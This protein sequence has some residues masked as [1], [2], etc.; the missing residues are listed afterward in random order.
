MAFHAPAQPAHILVVEDD[1]LLQ[2]ALSRVL[3]AAG[4]A[5]S[6]YPQAE[7]MLAEL[8]RRA[9]AGGTQAPI[10]ILMDVN[11]GSLSGID[12]QKLVR[13]I[14]ASTPVVFM[15][16][17]QDARDVNQAWRD[18]AA[19]FLFK[20]F[21]PKELLDTLEDALRGQAPL[22]PAPQAAAPL[23][24]ALHQN[25]AS[26]TRRQRQVLAGV[27]MGQT[28]QEMAERIGISPYTVKLHRAAMMQR[29]GCK[30]LAEVVR[31]Y[32]ACKHLLPPEL[33]HPTPA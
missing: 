16:A 1:F 17:Q 5:V 10:C 24:A 29:L 8:E 22:Q 23:D 7:P 28:H 26:L 12:A 18:G 33:P 19:N 4:H 27:A 21:T 14:D 9:E 6:I 30:N 15:S 3:A 31:L 2:R 13:Q 11:L 32:E 25:V 20:P